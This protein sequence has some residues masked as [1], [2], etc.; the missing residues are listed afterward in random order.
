MRVHN[1]GAQAE[2]VLRRGDIGKAA[3]IRAVVH[4]HNDARFERG[5]ES[6]RLSC[7][8]GVKP[9]HRDEQH[10]HP[11][12]RREQRRGEHMPQVAQMHEAQT[13]GIN[14]ADEIFAAQSAALAVVK[15]GEAADFQRR[16]PA[17]ESHAGGIIVVRMSVAAK[18]RVRRERGQEQ[19]R[20]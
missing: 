20:N 18:R 13:L 14:D 17:A 12:K 3:G 10:I 19:P 7:V 4:G 5:A 2:E 15:A 11:P 9:A 6:L 8:N 16:L 1:I